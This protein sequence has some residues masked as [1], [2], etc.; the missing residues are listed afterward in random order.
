[1]EIFLQNQDY[2]VHGEQDRFQSFSTVKVSDKGLKFLHEL[3]VE[4]P[5]RFNLAC[6]GLLIKFKL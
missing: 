2:L 5:R 6:V 4:E 3:S 1:M